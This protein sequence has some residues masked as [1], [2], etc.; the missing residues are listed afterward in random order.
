ML[1]VL[2]LQIQVSMKLEIICTVVFILTEKAAIYSMLSL[3]C[4]T[5]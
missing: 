5:S 4:I 2:L 1:P 3:G